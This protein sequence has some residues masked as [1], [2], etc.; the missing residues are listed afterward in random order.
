MKRRIARL[1]VIIAI[2]WLTL[3][4]VSTVFRA[5]WTPAAVDWLFG[6]GEGRIWA[7]NGVSYHGWGLG[8][9]EFIW[10]R[11]SFAVDFWA[12]GSLYSGWVMRE[13][14][15]VTHFS[16]PIGTRLHYLDIPLWLPALVCLIPGIWLWRRSRTHPKGCCQQCG[17]D[18]T[19]NVSGKCPE[20]ATD[21]PEE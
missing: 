7:E 16:Y 4:L 8:N 20:C 3:F 15:F 6:M 5:Q 2:G 18:L 13:G 21:V 12:S 9:G 10:Y 17:Y 11:E 14:M 1:L 19:G